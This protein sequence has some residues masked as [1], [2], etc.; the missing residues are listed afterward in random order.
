MNMLRV[1]RCIDAAMFELELDIKALERRKKLDDYEEE[2]LLDANEL[3]VRIIKVKVHAKDIYKKEKKKE[4]E[5]MS[6]DDKKWWTCSKE[7]DDWAKAERN[8]N[9]EET[10]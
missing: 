9:K 4:E 3:L 1:L 6:E 10:R 2:Y 7:M 8:K 5:Q